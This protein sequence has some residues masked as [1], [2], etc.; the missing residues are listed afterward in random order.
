MSRV[1]LTADGRYLLDNSVFARADR[2][3]VAARLER[4]A[5]DQLVSCGPLVIEALY[6]ARDRDALEFL[7]QRLTRSMPYVE[8]DEQVWRLALGAQVELGR[9][10]ERFH[11]RPPIDYLIAATA[12]SNGL[13]VLH[14]DRDYDLIAEHSSLDFDS[15][16][17]AAPGSL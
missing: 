16:W 10:N 5:P 14:Y 4:A 11:R 8:A 12:H 6:S 1:G 15:R 9:V 17:I 13:G 3:Q 2:P 7:H